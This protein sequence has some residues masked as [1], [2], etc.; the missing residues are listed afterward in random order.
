MSKL[1][2]VGALCLLGLLAVAQAGDESGVYD[3][4]SG[5]S[6]PKLSTDAPPEFHDMDG[7]LRAKT[8]EELEKAMD[9]VKAADDKA[10]KC[11]AKPIV[12]GAS[13]T[14][15]LIAVVRNAEK[16]LK[17]E[18]DTE[19]ALKRAEEILKDGQ[20][21]KEECDEAMA[22]PGKKP[23][24]LEEMSEMSKGLSKS[25]TKAR[26][27]RLIVRFF[28]WLF[29]IVEEPRIQHVEMALWTAS[30]PCHSTQSIFGNFIGW[31]H[32]LN[33]RYS[34]AGI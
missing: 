27:W 9:A 23:A 20:V 17:A 3:G 15:F 21:T 25:R 33:V 4:D 34:Y 31:N 26:I 30:T 14:H 11:S 1:V 32:H 28:R 10:V 18:K 24:F 12:I 6:D 7:A 19:A 22:L 16:L 5:A 8:L 13:E 2:W 29:G